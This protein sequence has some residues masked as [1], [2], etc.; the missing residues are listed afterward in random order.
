MQDRRSGGKL[1]RF[2]GSHL[3]GA[4]IVLEVGHKRLLC[5]FDARH[6][7]GYGLRHGDAAIFVGERHAVGQVPS[8]PA[9]GHLQTEAERRD[10][11]DEDLVVGDIARRVPFRLKCLLAGRRRLLLRHDG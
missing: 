2:D 9:F 8:R 3:N 4:R 6:L 7:R 1:D 10:V 5:L 11:V